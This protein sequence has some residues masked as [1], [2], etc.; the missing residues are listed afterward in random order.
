MQFLI[1][2]VLAALL[3]FSSLI[4]ATPVGTALSLGSQPEVCANAPHT[5]AGT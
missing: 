5:V 3:Q 4:S 2:A 1:I